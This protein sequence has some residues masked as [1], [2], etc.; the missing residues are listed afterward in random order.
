MVA[1]KGGGG[2]GEGG[3]GWVAVG[4]TARDSLYLYL[5]RKARKAK[6]RAGRR[7]WPARK[8]NVEMLGACGNSLF[9]E[10]F[11]SKYEVSK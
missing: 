6:A 7:G 11:Q 1:G 3:V 2:R 8:K 5:V 9:S 10:Y 4:S